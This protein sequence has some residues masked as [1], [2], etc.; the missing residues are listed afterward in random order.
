MGDLVAGGAALWRGQRWVARNPRWWVFGMV[1]ALLA[2]LVIWTLLGVLIYWLGD[3][4]AWATPF[5]DTWAPGLRRF[6]RDVVDALVLGGAALLSVVGFTALTLVI[7]QPFYERLVRQVSPPPPGAPEIGVLD[8]LLDG[9]RVGLRAA[10]WAIGLFV[11]GLVPVVGQVL[12]PPLGFCVSGYFLTVEL[13]TVAFELRG[14]PSERRLGGR[15]MLAIGFGAPLVIAFLVPF[16]TV[17]LM[18][19]A[20]AGAALLVDDLVA[21][22]E[23]A[24]DGNGEDGGRA[25]GVAQPREAEIPLTG[26]LGSSE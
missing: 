24:S 11:L 9:L 26:S 20:V 25:A 13:T 23:G 21:G 16:A 10:G 4:V 7:G 17:L 8:S 2:L 19:G 6:F 15:R 1:P 22:E 18:P 14:V 3:L 12:A 5:A